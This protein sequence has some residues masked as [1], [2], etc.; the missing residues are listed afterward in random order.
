MSGDHVPQIFLNFDYNQHITTDEYYSLEESVFSVI[1]VIPIALLVIVGIFSICNLVNFY[2][3]LAKLVK[4]RY[5]DTMLWRK[6]EKYLEKFRKIHDALAD[7][8]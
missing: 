7:I 4:R 2:K 6:V 3:N 1:I 8:D 5:S